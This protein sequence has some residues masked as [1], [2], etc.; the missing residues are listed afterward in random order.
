MPRILVCGGRDYGHVV[1]TKANTDD[2]PLAVKARLAE[3]QHIQ[4]FL[5]G[6][7]NNVSGEFK[8]EDNW[9][10]TD[11]VIIHGGAAGADS[12]AGDFAA[13]NWCPE[14]CFMAD[15]SKYGK[16][17]GYVRNKQMIEEGMPDL[18]VAFPG[19]RGTAMMVKLARQANIKVI[20][21]GSKGSF[22][23]YPAFQTDRFR[24]E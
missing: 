10:P 5:S 13:V 4:D 6:L 2:E 8:L 16:R 12:A 9:L 22:P 15:W 14:L 24:K 23:I 17:A 3:Y 7:V 19:G 18:V 11:V 1:R 20:E 21:V